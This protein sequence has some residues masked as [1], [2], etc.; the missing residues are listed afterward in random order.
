MN[1]E[2][3]VSVSSGYGYNTHEYVFDDRSEAFDFA[4]I[5][6]MHGKDVKVKVEFN[7]EECNE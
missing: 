4:E 2:Y 6:F 3:V 7:K 1:T 5:A